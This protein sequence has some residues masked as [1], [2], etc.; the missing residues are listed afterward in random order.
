MRL[1]SLE[2]YKCVE[3]YSVPD[4]IPV[5]DF[6]F[7]ESK[8]TWKNQYAVSLCLVMWDLSR[9]PPYSKKLIGGLMLM[10]N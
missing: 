9:M 4:I 10:H 1:W 2:S 7:D 8:V 3:E 5:V 6:D